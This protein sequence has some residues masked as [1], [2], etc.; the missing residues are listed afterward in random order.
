MESTRRTFG[1]YLWVGGQGTGLDI[2][3]HQAQAF[4]TLQDHVASTMPEVDHHMKLLNMKQAQA[5]VIQGCNAASSP[6][7]DPI[8]Y[9][10][11]LNDLGTVTK[12]VC[13]GEYNADNIFHVHALLLTPSRTDSI[14]R[15]MLTTFNKLQTA[16]GFRSLYGQQNT[17]DTLKL[18]KAYKPESI[19][20]YF[21][22]NPEWVCSNDEGLLQ[23]AYDIY[24][25]DLPERFRGKAEET[26]SDEMN[27]MAREIVDV[28]IENNCTT[29]DDCYKAAPLVMAKYLH[30][31]GLKGVVE[32]CLAFTAASAKAWTL[33]MMANNDIDPETIHKCLLHQ[34]IT[35]SYFDPIFYK[36][37]TKTDSKRNTLCLYGPSNTGKSGFIA[38]LKSIV[39]W[40]ELVN[41]QTFFAEGLPG[42]TIGIW[43]EPL[44]SPEQAEKC[45]Q[46]FEGMVTSIPV[47]YKKPCMLPRTP[48][49]MT[50][51]HYPWRFCTQEKD[52]FL[53][54]M[55]IID[56][57][58]QCKDTNYTPRAREHSCKCRY[59][60]ASRGGSPTHGDSVVATMPREQQPLST[61]E[62]STRST[63][64]P[65]VGSGSLS[66]RGTGICRCDESQCGSSIHDTD[67]SGTDTTSTTSSTS[68]DN[69]RDMGHRSTVRSSNTIHRDDST[70]SRYDDTMESDNSTRSTRPH[71]RRDGSNITRQLNIN[72]RRRRT[73]TP[74]HQHDILSLLVASTTTADDQTNIPAKKQKVDQSLAAIKGPFKIPMYVPLQV[75]WRNYLCYLYHMYG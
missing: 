11:I 2:S 29:I 35:P 48:I 5:T 47:K 33:S 51:N 58:Y 69:D 34:G 15:T 19:F 60:S 38:G 70:Q 43:E 26:S 32:N 62:Q 1:C 16:E 17:M 59:C 9:A 3:G 68:T 55:W 64:E 42:A 24:N 40:G 53:N 8:F 73:T 45:K 27:A 67:I 50:T 63:S 37:I 12:W 25:W 57:S 4:L 28:I 46:L 36:W 7:E 22:K 44:I 54:R 49:L 13:V 65:N 18:Q 52:M 56:F 75:D 71:S 74:A 14:R 66:E 30:R 6:I 72:R 10:M 20:T 61:G 39:K 31:P 41:T 23:L 21:M